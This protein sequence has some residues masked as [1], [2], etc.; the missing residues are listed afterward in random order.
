MYEIIK[1][2]IIH[3]LFFLFIKCNMK[4]NYLCFFCFVI[5]VCC[6]SFNLASASEPLQNKV[7]VLDAGHGGVDP[8]T[9]VGSVY[10]KD[11]NL[12]ITLFLKD[13]L[14][15]L[16]A[17]VLLTRMGDYDLSSPKAYMRKKSDF[18]HRI[19]FINHSNADYFISIHL[20][21]LSDSSYYGPQVFYN[22]KKEENKIL[23]EKV[24][25]FLNKKLNT[26]REAKKISNTI[27]MYSRLDVPGILVECGFLSNSKEKNQLLLETY[28]KEF[29]TFLAEAFL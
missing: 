10:E 23:A 25:S 28:Q 17:K 1:I 5:L 6:F 11:I 7:F 18:D 19:S 13:E 12:K 20:N 2:Y 15:R 16:G 3:K 8:G 26:N 9:V 29:S 27:Y 21:Y 14:T 4:K 22:I 24:Q